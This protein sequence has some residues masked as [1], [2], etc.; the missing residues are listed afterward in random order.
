MMVM[1]DVSIFNNNN[2]KKREKRIASLL[3]W[4]NHKRCKWMHDNMNFAFVEWFAN[5]KNW[6]ILLGRVHNG[7]SSRWIRTEKTKKNKKNISIMAVWQTA[8]STTIV[9]CSYLSNIHLI[10]CVWQTLHT[11]KYNYICLPAMNRQ[12][13]ARCSLVVNDTVST[14]FSFVQMFFFFCRAVHVYTEIVIFFFMS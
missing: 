14:A 12:K 11:T 7:N 10:V 3:T 6:M 2:N 8:L 4:P 9:Q 5:G 1:A 13:H